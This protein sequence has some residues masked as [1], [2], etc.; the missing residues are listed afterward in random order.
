MTRVCRS[1]YA[2]ETYA[3]EE[4]V[5]SSDIVRGFLSEMCGVSLEDCRKDLA[6]LDQVECMAVVDA[7][8]T[9]DKCSSDTS[10]QGAQNPW[11][12]RSVTRNSSSDEEVTQSDGSKQ[13]TNWRTV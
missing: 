10:S 5:D 8:D 2:A 1:A 6:A 9:H 12:S 11:H 13:R 7:K 3:L 4:G